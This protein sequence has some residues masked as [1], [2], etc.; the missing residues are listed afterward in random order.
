MNKL[1]EIVRRHCDAPIKQKTAIG[2]RALKHEYRKILDASNELKIYVSDID[3]GISHEDP[4]VVDSSSDKISK[5]CDIMLK[6]I[7]ALKASSK[8]L[9]KAFETEYSPK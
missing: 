9:W 7:N 2:L 1:K 6:H 4:N 3:S 5:Q 8:N